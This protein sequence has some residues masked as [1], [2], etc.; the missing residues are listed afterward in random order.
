MFQFKIKL[1]GFIIGIKTIH[2]RPFAICRD[3][4]VDE[5]TPDFCVETTLDDIKYE[6]VKYLEICKGSDPWEGELE[7]FALLRKISDEILNHGAFL[8]HG[9]AIGIGDRAY[10]FTAPSGTGKTTH[11]LK[12]VKEYHDVTIINGDK[13]FILINKNNE[14]Y[15]CGSP[16]A[17]KESFY[18]NTMLPLKA[19]VMLERN[20]D[21][22]INQVSYMDAFPFFY[23]QVYR[24]ED[25]NRIRKTLQLMQH[26]YGSV[27]FYKFMLNNYKDD[28]L[29]VAAKILE[30]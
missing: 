14:P 19:I 4:I 10:L 28:C 25:E 20:D 30:E 23:R 15:V 17:G 1:A 16:W 11:I 7:T 26:L 24:P 3:Y 8:V 22:I 18:N 27:S 5:G 13:P 9:A 29:S 2:I 21:N 6:R 12:W